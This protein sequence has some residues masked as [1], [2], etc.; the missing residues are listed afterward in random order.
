MLQ[1]TKIRT[2]RELYF[3]CIDEEHRAMHIPRYN[4]TFSMK[5]R[6]EA[7]LLTIEEF[8]KSTIS[9]KSDK[10]NVYSDS[11]S[12]SCGEQDAPSPT[13]LK[14]FITGLPYFEPLHFGFH[15]PNDVKAPSCLCPCAWGL[16]CW[17]SNFS[18][19][20]EDEVSFKF[21]AFMPKSLMQHCATK[22]GSYH[23]CVLLYLGKLNI[24]SNQTW[25]DELTSYGNQR[26][27]VNENTGSEDGG[28]HG[29]F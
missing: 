3:D 22:G 19:D 21:Q 16:T 14:N 12:S 7:A 11:D 17:R 6:K 20:W 24:K 4:Y 23:D 8:V 27:D 28:I 29:E 18:I 15:I 2:S 13:L 5:R 25:I 9:L 1:A 26:G 10:G